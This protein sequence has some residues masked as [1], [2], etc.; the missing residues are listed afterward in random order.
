M[1]IIVQLYKKVQ[2]SIHCIHCNIKHTKNMSDS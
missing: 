1:Y 2:W